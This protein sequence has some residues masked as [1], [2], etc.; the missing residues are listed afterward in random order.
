MKNGDEWTMVG[1]NRS[2]FYY[3]ENLPDDII[4]NICLYLEYQDIRVLKRNN[5]LYK[6]INTNSYIWMNL[7]KFYFRWDINR[8]EYSRTIFLNEVKNMKK[9]INNITQNNFNKKYDMHINAWI[10]L[11]NLYKFIQYNTQYSSIDYFSIFKSDLEYIFPKKEPCYFFHLRSIHN[12]KFILISDILQALFDQSKHYFLYFTFCLYT[13][14]KSSSNM[15]IESDIKNFI[16]GKIIPGLYCNIKEAV[17]DKFNQRFFISTDFI[18]NQL[19][20]K[21]SFLY[22]DDYITSL[23]NLKYSK[24][25]S[26]I[27]FFILKLNKSFPSLFSKYINTDKIQRFIK[28]H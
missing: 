14:I 18:T 21:M 27:D 1:R 13:N 7:Y 19:I 20:S 12:N 24:H 16:L 9:I 23:P 11:Y 3:M 15:S 17:T 28:F 25:Q 22:F 4:T 2:K 8:K 5:K 6:I 26:Y 10:F